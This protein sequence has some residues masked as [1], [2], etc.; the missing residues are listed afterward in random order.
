MEQKNDN[1]KKISRKRFFNICGSV[2]A[3][4]SIVGLTSLFLRNNRSSGW[5]QELSLQE[6]KMQQRESI[7]SPYKLVSSFS[8]PDRIDCFEISEDKL[9]VATL[10]NIYMYD[11]KGRL[12]NNFAVGSNVRDITA[13]SKKIY[14]LYPTRIETY[15]MDGQWISDWEACSP[16]SD[17]CQLALTPGYVFVTD[18]AN[19]NICK[20]TTEGG[21]V[22]FVQS[23]NGFIIPSY[24]FGIAY[25]NGTIYCSNP[26]RHQV[27]SYSVDGGYIASFGKAGGAAG[28]FCGCCNPVYLS[29]TSNG[30][31]ITSEKGNPRISCYGSDGQFRSVLL[32]SKS[33]GGGNTAYDVKIQKDKI[34]VAGKNLISVFRYDNTPSANTS[35]SSCKGGCPLR[36]GINS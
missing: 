31:I 26:G 28:L 2:I 6:L 5:R 22:S 20:Y 34:F 27:E 11:R 24:T 4:S 36:Q 32:D 25:I 15:G 8:V 33:L 12:L 13:D 7:N 18:A 9:I 10:N 19:K 29:S 14:V 30:D 1:S 21:F 35:C 3:G 23:P 17:Y 16:E